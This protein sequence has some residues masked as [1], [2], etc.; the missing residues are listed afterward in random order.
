MA[1]QVALL[2]EQA[3]AKQGRFRVALSG[4]SLLDILSPKLVTDPLRSKINWTAW[5]VFWADERCLPL[6][7]PDSN[8]AAANMLLFKHVHI[9]RDQIHPVDYSLGPTDAAQAYQETI[10]DVLQP[11]ACHLPRF[12]LILLGMGQDGHTAS[13]FPGHVLLQE[14]QKWVAPVYD[15]PKPPKERI[16]LTLPVINHARQVIF[17]ATGE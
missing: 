6:S 5:E 8:F 2:A 12:D 11:A 15:A 9:P 13:L 4:G 17:V 14:K 3:T 7:S 10:K 1:S 16:T